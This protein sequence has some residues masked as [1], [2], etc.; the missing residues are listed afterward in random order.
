MIYDYDWGN[1]AAAEAYLCIKD[2]Y[3]QMLRQRYGLKLSFEA[4]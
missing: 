1:G 2:R 3:G 4:P